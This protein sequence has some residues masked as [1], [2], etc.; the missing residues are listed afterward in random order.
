MFLWRHFRATRCRFTLTTIFYAFVSWFCLIR[1]DICGSPNGFA[2]LQL[3]ALKV[4]I[5]RTL[6]SEG[7]QQSGTFAERSVWTLV[8]N[9]SWMIL[10]SVLILV[11]CCFL[12]KERL[13]ILLKDVDACLENLDICISSLLERHTDFDSVHA[14]F[15][16]I[17]GLEPESAWLIAILSLESYCVTDFWCHI[18][19]QESTCRFQPTHVPELSVWA[20]KGRGVW[21]EWHH[22]NQQRSVLPLSYAFGKVNA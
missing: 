18:R 21:G 15:G 20:I 12:A 22:E 1:E 17:P 8:A 13:G 10:F 4:W 9:Q 7:L 14:E 3:L 6:E 2:Q 19:W 5:L 16:W 11:S